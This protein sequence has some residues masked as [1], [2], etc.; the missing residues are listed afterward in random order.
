MCLI[1]IQVDVSNLWSRMGPHEMLNTLMYG[2]ALFTSFQK[3]L[4]LLVK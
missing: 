2:I 4:K 3:Y 1:K